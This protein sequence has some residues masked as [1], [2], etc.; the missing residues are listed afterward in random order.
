MHRC[1]KNVERPIA[2]VI[3]I[4]GAAKINIAILKITE[5]LTA[6]HPQAI[7]AAPANP[8]ISVCDEEDGIPHHQVS[9]FQVIAARTPEKIIGKVIYCSNTV[10]ETVFAMPNS[11]IIYFDTI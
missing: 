10:L 5:E 7:I 11:P 3:P 9:K 6:C 1:I 4:R 2:Q 8:P